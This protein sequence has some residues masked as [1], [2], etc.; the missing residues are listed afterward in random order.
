MNNDKNVGDNHSASAGEDTSHATKK[1]EAEPQVTPRDNG[2]AGKTDSTANNN[3]AP[4]GAPEIPQVAG[5]PAGQQP[6]SHA[7]PE[8]PFDLSRLRLSQDFSSKLGVRKELIAVPVSK[9]HRQEW[10]RVHPDPAMRFT[11]ALLEWKED[12]QFYLVDPAVAP[13]LLGEIFLAEL[14]VTINRNGDL[15]L[16]PVKLPGEDGR[17]HEA[18]RTAFEAAQFATAKWVRVVWNKSL[19]AYDVYTA[20]FTDPQWPQ[21]DLHTLVKTG[22]KERFIRTLDHPIAR[23]L[24]GV[25]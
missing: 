4:G 15:N 13:E 14:F 2:G 25:V 8:D 17:W 24:R 20:S 22:F 19:G 6:Q 18:H 7:Q 12:G 11:T 3:G 9:R 1:G 5:T 23:S 16:W 21:V 10:F